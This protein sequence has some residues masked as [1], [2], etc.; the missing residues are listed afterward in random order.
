[1]TTSLIFDGG[2][3][4]A[5]LGMITAAINSLGGYLRPGARTAEELDY[6]RTEGPLRHTPTVAEVAEWEEAVL[7]DAATGP[8]GDPREPDERFTQGTRVSTLA[9]AEHFPEPIEPNPDPDDDGPDRARLRDWA[10]KSH[11]RASHREV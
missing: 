7:A 2:I 11:P 6:M 4:L 8:G 5:V 3:Y 10:E 1:M 9:P